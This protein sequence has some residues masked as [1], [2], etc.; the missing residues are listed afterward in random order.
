M[1]AIDITR[2]SRI[3]QQLVPSTTILSF[4]CCSQF[5]CKEKLLM[6][7]GMTLIFSFGT[8]WAVVLSPVEGETIF[9]K[10]NIRGTVKCVFQSL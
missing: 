1:H 9:Q 10:Y 5:A 7:F 2:H 3:T 8:F 4:V 6:T